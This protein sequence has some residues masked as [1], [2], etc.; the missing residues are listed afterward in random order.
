MYVNS[1][2]AWHGCLVQKLKQARNGPSRRTAHGSKDL[3]FLIMQKDTIV[4]LLRQKI[5][6]LKNPPMPEIVK[7]A[8]GFSKIQFVSHIKKLKGAET[9]KT[10]K[11]Y[12][13]KSHIADNIN[14][15]TFRLSR[16]CMLR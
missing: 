13:T 2:I 8:L 1:R 11:I 12:D 14:R 10:L 6:V 9:F 16:F 3:S 4:K 5:F 15:E 7:G